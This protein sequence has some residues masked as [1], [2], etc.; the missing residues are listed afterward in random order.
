[1]LINIRNQQ[2]A[3]IKDDTAVS[4]NI[5]W[6]INGSEAK[7]RKLV[8]DMQKLLLRAFNSECDE[9]IS[10]VKYNNY[11]TSVKKMEQ[12]FNTI[13]LTLEKWLHQGSLDCNLVK[14]KGG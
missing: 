3:I 9:I 2:K 12:S 4:G 7:G 8:K 1:M 13:L 6:Q 11:D 14:Y 5:G 10:K